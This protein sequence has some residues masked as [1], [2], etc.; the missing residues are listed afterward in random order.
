ML[1]LKKLKSENI[2][3]LLAQSRYSNKNLDFSNISSY[4]NLQKAKASQSTK[5]KIEI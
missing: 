3:K 1:N 2:R 5:T 4:K